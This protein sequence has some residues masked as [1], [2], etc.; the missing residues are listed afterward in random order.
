MVQLCEEHTGIRLEWL[1]SIIQ[2][3]EFL[4]AGLLC[5]ELIIACLSIYGFWKL[6]SAE[7]RQSDCTNTCLVVEV[8][9]AVIWKKG[10]KKSST[11]LQRVPHDVLHSCTK[12]FVTFSI[13]KGFMLRA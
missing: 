8:R 3:T 1:N 4:M 9:T 10:V 12:A 13:P 5:N 7:V 2:C 11:R 6:G